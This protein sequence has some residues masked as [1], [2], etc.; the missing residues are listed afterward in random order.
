[1]AGQDRTEIINSI[2]KSSPY[3]VGTKEYNDLKARLNA[4]KE[5]ELKTELMRSLQGNYKAPW[6]MGLS[7]ESKLAEPKPETP[8]AQGKPKSESTQQQEKPKTVEC[9]FPIPYSLEYIEQKTKQDPVQQ[10]YE[11]IA[12]TVKKDLEDCGITINQQNV[13]TFAMICAIYDKSMEMNQLECRNFVKQYQDIIFKYKS[14]NDINGLKKELLCKLNIDLYDANEKEQTNEI[15]LQNFSANILFG[16]YNFLADGYKNLTESGSITFDVAD[17]FVELLGRISSSDYIKALKDGANSFLDLT[18]DKMSSV[19]FKEAFKQVFNKEYDEK[20]ADDLMQY[21]MKNSQANILKDKTFKEKFIALFGENS[22]P[23]TA[24]ELNKMEWAAT[25]GDVCL[26][27]ASFDLIHNSSL[28]QNLSLN[29]KAFYGALGLNPE[30]LATKIT[31]GA[32]SMGAFT[33]LEKTADNLIKPNG[34]SPDEWLDIPKEVLVALPFGGFA[35]LV[36]A[37]AVEPVFK[38]VVPILEEYGPNGLKAAE[39]ALASGKEV[40]FK[41]LTKI[42]YGATTKE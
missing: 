26:T 17:A 9:N 40:S 30:G 33:A 34:A 12:N 42:F 22:L 16:T 14:A 29:T 5:E 21:C 31:L 41:E 8:Q 20:A 13:E 15:K 32:A 23:K 36:Q 25:I 27:L 6:N 28:M 37:K 39:E 4:M 35:S 10:Q 1:M 2:L 3:V 24:M 11:S 38:K 18:P 7:I 19:E